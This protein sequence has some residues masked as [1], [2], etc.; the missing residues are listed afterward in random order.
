[1]DLAIDEG[2]IIYAEIAFGRVMNKL[3]IQGKVL[4]LW[5]QIVP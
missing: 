5:W 1:L 3:I 2:H 4:Y